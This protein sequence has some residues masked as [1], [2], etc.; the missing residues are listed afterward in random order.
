MYEIDKDL[1]TLLKLGA[2]IKAVGHLITVLNS[3]PLDDVRQ[4]LKDGQRL[5]KAHRHSSP[6]IQHGDQIVQMTLDM[7]GQY[8]KEI[9][10]LI[11]QNPEVFT[12]AIKNEAMAD[13]GALLKN[14]KNDIIH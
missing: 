8:R 10:E 14:L 3:F 11:E 12:D 1:Q 9:Q 5:V 6:I 13:W 4:I 2:A 7:V